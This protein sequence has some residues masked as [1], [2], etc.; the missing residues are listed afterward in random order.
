[1][2]I[3]CKRR[4]GVLKSLNVNEQLGI[5]KY[6]SVNQND[7]GNLTMGAAIPCHI[8]IIELRPAPRKR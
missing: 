4:N 7:T 6:A 8:A 1:M 2:P 5:P 3:E